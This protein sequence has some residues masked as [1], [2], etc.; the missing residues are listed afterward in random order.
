[1]VDARI[2]AET[3]TIF[4]TR[5][6]NGQYSL[7]VPRGTRVRVMSFFKRDGE[8]WFKAA[9]PDS[10]HGN[11]PQNLENRIKSGLESSSWDGSGYVNSTSLEL[12]VQADTIEEAT[13]IHSSMTDSESFVQLTRGTRILLW[14]QTPPLKEA[15]YIEV[16]CPSGVGY[17]NA[18]TR[19]KILPQE[20]VTE[21]LSLG[22]KV[23]AGGIV[24]GLLLL[25]L[26]VITFLPSEWRKVVYILSA[27]AVGTYGAFLGMKKKA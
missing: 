11:P 3:A 16:E 19:V 4:P 7:I 15:G 24:I 25:I 20:K 5:T 21:E 23:G 2:S 17:V 13:P 14:R 1:M 10:L 18:K 27:L 9:F 12:P 22:K 8:T 26:L 6:L